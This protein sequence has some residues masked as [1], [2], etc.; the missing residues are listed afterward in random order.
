MYLLTKSDIANLT[1]I[2]DTNI[3]DDVIEFAED[4]VKRKLAKDYDTLAETEIYSLYTEQSYIQLKHQN[5]VAVSVFTIEDIN[6]V[7]LVESDDDYKLFKEEGIIYCTSLTTFKTITLTY[8]YGA[9]TVEDLDKYLH[10]LYALKMI[11]STNPDIIPDGKKSEKIGDYS[12]SYNSADLKE[13]PQIID[14]LINQATL[15]SENTLHFL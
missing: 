8:T 5:I 13:Q 12:I 14:N 9:C 11:I 1:G 10:L 4:Q 6:E 15:S 2:T 7:G 3:P